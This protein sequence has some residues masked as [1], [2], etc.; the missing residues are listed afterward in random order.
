MCQRLPVPSSPNLIKKEKRKKK[1]G[2]YNRVGTLSST[3]PED[4]RNEEWALKDA[5]TR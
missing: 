3:N 1:K 5:T 4:V 2:L